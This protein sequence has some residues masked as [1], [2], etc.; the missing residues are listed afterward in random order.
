M[1][2]KKSTKPS[3]A[4]KTAKKAVTVAAAN[5]TLVIGAIAIPI[6]V[7]LVYK[8]VKKINNVGINNPDLGSGSSDN[9]Y[10]P[11]PKTLSTYQANLI[12]SSVYS[13]INKTCL[14]NSCL[15]KMLDDALAAL[16]PIKSNSDYALVS[17]AFGKPRFDGYAEAWFPFPQRNMT[18]WLQTKF[19]TRPEKYNKLKELIPGI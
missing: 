16:S 19:R 2:K 7:Y 5:P 6:A 12:A 14:T 18:Y 4:E 8:V 3:K 11:S 13:I 9:L 1:S 17:E 10:D 15:D